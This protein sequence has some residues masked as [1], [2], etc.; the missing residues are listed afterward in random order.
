MF[1]L[2]VIRLLFY[3]KIEKI[4]IFKRCLFDFLCLQQ[5]GLIT[6]RCNKTRLMLFSFSLFFLVC[7]EDTECFICQWMALCDIIL[8]Y[9]FFFDI[10]MALMSRK[11]SIGLGFFYF[12]LFIDIRMLIFVFINKAARHSLY[13]FILVVKKAFTL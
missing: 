6:Y 2:K 3:V 7:E 10:R 5:S 9:S 1:R 8:L 11:N 13:K 4:K 12:L